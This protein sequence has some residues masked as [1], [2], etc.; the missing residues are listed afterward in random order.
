MPSRASPER[1]EDLKEAAA[2]L[3]SGLASA[4]RDPQK[5]PVLKITPEQ[6]LKLNFNPNEAFVLSRI[7]SAWDVKSILKISPIKE[8]EVLLI[9]KRFYAEGLIA[10]T[11]KKAP[12][13]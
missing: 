5:I 10:S 8:I 13:R 9:F 2:S 3:R 7:N 6:S 4:G 11:E 12:H 1:S